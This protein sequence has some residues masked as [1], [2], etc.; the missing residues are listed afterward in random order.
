MAIKASRVPHVHIGRSDKA[1][2]PLGMGGSFY[3]LDHAHRQGE[4]DILA[5]LETALDVGIAHFD[6]TTG[7]GDG[8]SEQLLNRSQPRCRF[9]GS[10]SFSPPKANLDDIS[11]PAI[12][13]GD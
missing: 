13:C 4:A 9:C 2:L 7:Y 10:R 6:T 12:I 1:Q 5:A 3:G 8:Y 11:A